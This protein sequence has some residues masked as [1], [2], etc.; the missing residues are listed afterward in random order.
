VKR[1]EFIYLLVAAGVCPRAASAQQAAIPSVGF[2]ALAGYVREW[3]DAFEA[4]LREQGRVPGS[5][6]RVEQRYADSNFDR[7]R[8]QIKA[9]LAGG[10]TVFVAAGS[11]AAGMIQELSSTAAIVVPSLEVFETARVAGTIARP[12]GQVTGFATLQADLISKR[13]EFL[14][15]IVPG[16]RRIAF[17]VNQRN[18]N[19]AI[20]IPAFKAATDGMGLAMEAVA[21]SDVGQIEG[22]LK[23][24]KAEGADT[25]VF[26]RDFS[27]ESHRPVLV[28]AAM[29]AGLPSVFDDA[30]FV[31][32]AGLLSYAPDRSDLFRRAAAYVV[33]LLDGAR[34]L[35]LP[36]QLPVKF[37]LVI[38]MRTA[39]AL[40]LS[41]PPMV[42]A[43][44]NEV[45]E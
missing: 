12:Q 27:F 33:K 37:E 32:L 30:A 22:A 6:I 4:G 35:D 11:N 34:P 39:K 42:L 45:I 2:I 31:R 29:A 43:L 38:N 41:I 26:M 15:E 1:R 18:R 36:I 40:G 25:V 20:M 7:S 21:V 8:E 28:S 14:R 24:A 23:R 5:T 13:I 10:T 44:A 19:H 3:I 16:M 9:L 17:V